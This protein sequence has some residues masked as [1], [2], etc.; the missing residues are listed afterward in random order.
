[1][2]H[3]SFSFNIKRPQK[4]TN[5]AATIL[6][7]MRKK[8]PYTP[9][10]AKSTRLKV[11][12]ETDLMT[13]LLTKM[14]G[15]KRNSV[16]SLLAH[17]QVMVNGKITTL[18]NH[19]L[20]SGYDVEIK[21][22]RGNIELTHPKLRVLF[23]D[24]DLIVVEKKEG[25]LTVSTGKEEDTTAFSILKNYVKKSSPRNRIFIVHRLDRETSGVLVF[26]KNKDIQLILQENWHTIVTRRTYIA[27]VEGK[28]EKQKDTIISW[29][30][31]NEKS[32]KIHSGKEIDG[33]RKAV[34][35]YRRL[36]SNEHFSLLELELETGRKNQIRVHLQS[37]G[38]PISGDKKYG[39]LG[40]PLGRIALHASIL[41]FYHPVTRE[42][43]SFEMPAPKAFTKV[44]SV[45]TNP[46]I[47]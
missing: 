29:L 25:L 1:L 27:L 14:G 23:E 8:T 24:N 11:D 16:K 47:P 43:L 33:S 12:S 31:E 37:I 4:N 20:K 5:F 36:K 34:T 39:S 44:F 32:L 38:H 21:S 17:R 41:A 45:K 15:M 30:Y 6:F 13:F 42:K 9:P 19:P 2:K 22:T 40:S 26:A 3:G 46:Q 10:P 35:H 7:K 18:Y 28:V